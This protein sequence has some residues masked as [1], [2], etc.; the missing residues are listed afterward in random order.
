MKIKIDVVPER[1]N[2]LC[3]A[4]LI[5]M[6]ATGLHGDDILAACP[7]RHRDRL[8]KSYMQATYA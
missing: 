2:D 5:S 3:M 4:N 6:A 7:M 8:Y 1:F